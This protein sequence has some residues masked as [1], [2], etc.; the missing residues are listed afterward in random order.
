MNLRR[1]RRNWDDFGKVDPLWAILTV[2]DK[3]GNKWDIKEFFDSGKKEIELVFSHLQSLDVMVSRHRALDF[4]CGVG[5]LTQALGGCFEEVYGVDIAP[6]MINTARKYNRYG[7]RCKYYLNAESN[8][9][10]FSDGIFDLIYTNIV[11]QH[12]KPKYIRNYIKEFLRLLNGN[13]IL[14]FQL[15]SERIRSDRII[16][17]IFRHIVPA[18]LLDRVFYMRIYLKSLITK[19]PAMEMYSIKKEE[20]INF[21]EENKAKVVDIKKDPMHHGR[22]ESYVYFVMKQ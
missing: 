5:R 2:P 17:E 4:G 13:G 12:M 15:P 18:S 9:R 11:L 1:L 21:L 8:L 7:E 16:S 19:G 6:S 20:L 14:I 10:L 22:W 3:K